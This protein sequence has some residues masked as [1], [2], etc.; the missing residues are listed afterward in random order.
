M[1]FATWTQSASAHKSDT[2]LLHTQWYILYIVERFCSLHILYVILIRMY[3]LFLSLSRSNSLLAGMSLPRNEERHHQWR[4][5]MPAGKAMWKTIRAHK[6]F[7][8]ISSVSRYIYIYAHTMCI[9]CL[10]LCVCVCVCVY[11]PS[12]I[13]LKPSQ[14]IPSPARNCFSMLHWWSSISY[15]AMRYI[16]RKR[17]MRCE[18]QNDSACDYYYSLCAE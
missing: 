4:R 3:I 5:F 9:L 10:S 8:V 14:V 18:R 12:F 15:I 17:H 1:T 7:I 11:T 2:A 6:Y 13:F 16:F